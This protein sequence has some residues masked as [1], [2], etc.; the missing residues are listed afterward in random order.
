MCYVTF[1]LFSVSAESGIS[2]FGRPLVL[3]LCVNAI[4]ELLY[5]VDNNNS[6]SSQVKSTSPSAIKPGHC[7][8]HTIS[9]AVST[10]SSNVFLD[11]T[12][13][14]STIL[15]HCANLVPGNE[16]ADLPN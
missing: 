6:Y 8:M 12:F 1:G 3:Y 9:K 4:M 15:V 10:G 2:T 16:L 7:H 5:L 14:L 13:K 11:L